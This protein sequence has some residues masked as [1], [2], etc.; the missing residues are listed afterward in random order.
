MGL[1]PRPSRAPPVRLVAWVYRREGLAG[2]AERESPEN[3]RSCSAASDVVIES[4]VYDATIPLSDEALQP[5]LH[6]ASRAGISLTELLVVLSV[7]SVI[8][9]LAGTMIHRLLAA[10]NEATRAARFAAS[11]SRLSRAFRA[12]VHAARAVEFPGAIVDQPAVLVATLDDRRQVQYEFDA[13]LVTRFETR[14]GAKVHREDFHFPPR[15]KLRC[16]RNEG[17]T[18][19]K[20]EFELAVRDPEPEAERPVRKLIVEATLA[21]DHRFEA[22]TPQEEQ[23][24]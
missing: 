9:G 19:L 18:L 23:A 11:V 8:I 22:S 14:E 21:R 1:R 2:Q 13:H 15:S 20:L 4:D 6:V 5:S 3:V 24:P 10:E 7:A 12:D 17:G 16:S